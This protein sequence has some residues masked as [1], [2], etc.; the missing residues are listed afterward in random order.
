M[1]SDQKIRVKLGLRRREIV[2]ISPEY[3]DA[4]V[5]ARAAGVPLREVYDKAIAEATATLKKRF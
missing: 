4:L 1:V 2:S 5:A 3:E